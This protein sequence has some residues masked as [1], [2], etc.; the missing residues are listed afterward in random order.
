MDATQRRTTR[1]LRRKHIAGLRSNCP[2][3][4]ARE[5]AFRKRNAGEK[6]SLIDYFI[7]LTIWKILLVDVS[8]NIMQHEKY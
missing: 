8:E 1:N 4:N 7:Y 5:E 3:G 6:N 2:N